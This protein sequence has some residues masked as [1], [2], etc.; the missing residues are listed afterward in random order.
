MKHLYAL[1]MMQLKD[2]LDFSF[3]KTKQKLISKI[4]FTILKFIIVAAVAYGIFTVLNL[5]FFNYGIKKELMVFIFAVIFFLSLISCTVGLMKNLYFADDNKVLITFPVNANLIFIS[6]LIVYYIFELKR[7]LFLTIPIFIAFGIMT[8]ITALYYL[9]LVVA[10]VFI[11]ALPVLFGSLLSIPA[12]YIYT[13]IKKRA[14]LKVGIYVIAIAAVVYGAVALIGLIPTSINLI[15]QKG[16]IT[17]HVNKF[18]MGCRTYCYPVN[19]LT[20]MLCG[21]ESGMTYNIFV[22]QVPIYFGVLVALLLIFFVLAYFV[23]RPLFFSMMSKTFE[24]E[25]IP[26]KKVQTDKK[27]KKGLTFF[28]AEIMSLMRSGF[29]GTFVAMYIIVPVMIYLLN[30]IFAA[31]DTKLSGV[32]M[33][34]AFNVLI[35]ILPMLASNALIATIYSRDGRAAYVTKTMPLDPR[36]PLAVKIAPMAVASAISLVISVVVFSRFVALTTTELIL[37]SV[38]LIGIQWGHIMWSAMLDIMNPQN[39][40]YATFGEMTDNPNENFSTIIAFII[41]AIYAVYSFILFPEGVTKACVKLC[42]IGVVFACILAYMFFTKIKV[43]YF[44]K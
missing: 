15:Q 18:L 42:A 11:S 6:R 25:K 33:V 40:Q 7:S 38:G 26:P 16:E 8:K 31:M 23:S 30:K 39:E 35:M 5:L 14:A 2:K 37:L 1:V 44:E 4:V 29:V 19:F 10:F 24:F 28:R 32:Y 41:A 27:R 17:A 20:T 9:W 13:F 21:N 12:L 22:K 3:L 36:F 43:Y 34:Y